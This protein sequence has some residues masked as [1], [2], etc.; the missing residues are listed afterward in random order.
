M[1]KKIEKRVISSPYS[2]FGLGS[3]GPYR[4]I[5]RREEGDAAG[6]AK[7]FSRAWIRRLKIRKETFLISCSNLRRASGDFDET[8]HLSWSSKLGVENPK[9]GMRFFAYPR[10][11]GG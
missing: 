3:P 7:T 2:S 6:R 5:R 10:R 8:S 9:K 11:A 4:R 1:T